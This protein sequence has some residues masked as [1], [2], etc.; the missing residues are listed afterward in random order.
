MLLDHWTPLWSDFEAPLTISLGHQL[1]PKWLH[2]N[3]FPATHLTSHINI[4][5]SLPQSQCRD[6][7]DILKVT[8]FS[9]KLVFLSWFTPNCLSNFE[10]EMKNQMYP[11]ISSFLQDSELLMQNLLLS[12]L[13][14]ILK[15]AACCPPHKL[16]YTHK[17][18][19]TSTP[20]TKILVQ[21][22]IYIY[23]TSTIS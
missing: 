1:A 15:Q 16:A 2:Q 19:H 7:L 23:I 20:D 4:P 13:Q 9:K 17:Y 21:P 3:R 12:A 18:T 10:S 6:H 11:S 8:W 22:Y 5:F 14:C